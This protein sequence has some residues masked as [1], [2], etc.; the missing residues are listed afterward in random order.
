PERFS[1]NVLLRGLFQCTLLPDVAFIGGGAEIAYW[2][3]VKKLFAAAAIPLPVL[4][5]RNSFLLV[6]PGAAKRLGNLGLRPE[7]LF[8]TTDQ[9]LRAIVHEATQSQHDLAQP[10]AAI[11]QLYQQVKEQAGQL[12]PT[13][14]AH[15]SSLEKRS[16]QGIEGLEKKMWRVIKRKHQEQQYQL[17]AL[18]AQLFPQGKLQERHQH[19]GVYY[20]QWGRELLEQLLVHSQGLAQEFTILHLP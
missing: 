17:H 2:L 9:Q 18:H 3:Q 7:Q 19:L 14:E 8:S 1:P 4:V 16:L 5:L 13:L 6:E 11:H 15:V 12:D 10:R 20:A